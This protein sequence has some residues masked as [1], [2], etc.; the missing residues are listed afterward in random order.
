MM[1]VPCFLERNERE[2]TISNRIVVYRKETKYP[3]IL[4]LCFLQYFPDF[5]TIGHFHSTFAR[6]WEGGQQREYF[7]ME[8]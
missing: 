1:D 7:C 5:C 2:F 4:N 3:L 8:G 6:R